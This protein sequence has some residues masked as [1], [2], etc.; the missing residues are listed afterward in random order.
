[1]YDY[2]YSIGYIATEILW[3]WL[4]ICLW[5]TLIVYIWFDLITREYE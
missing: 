5:G 3:I 4:L 2:W 1:M